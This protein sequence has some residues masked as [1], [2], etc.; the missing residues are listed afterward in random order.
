MSKNYFTG[1]TDDCVFC[2]IGVSPDAEAIDTG[3]GL[4]HVECRDRAK[5]I[6]AERLAAF[7][8]LKADGMAGI[9]L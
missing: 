8:S 3:N 9:A 2:G 7:E 4:L 5:T 6:A 1:P